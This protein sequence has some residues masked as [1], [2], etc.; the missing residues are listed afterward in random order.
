MSLDRLQASYFP[1]ETVQVTVHVESDKELKIQEGRVALICREEFQYRTTER[2]RDSQGRSSTRTVEHWMRSEQE[3]FRQVFLG[4]GSLAPMTVQTFQFA[5]SLPMNALPSL[6]GNIVKVS[7]FVKATLD[8]KMTSDINSEV[9]VNVLSAMPVETNPGSFGQSTEPG[10]VALSFELPELDY[11]P[12]QMISGSLLVAPQNKFDASE[13]RVELEQLEL[14]SHE[15][16]HRKGNKIQ[17]KLTGKTGFQPGNL[18]RI[19]FQVQ[20]PNPCLVS[21]A[22]NYWWV[23]FKLRGVL[24]RSL[25]KDTAVEVEVRIYSAR[26][27]S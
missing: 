12:G 6:V 23:G 15:Q 8:R 7:W 19:P 2:Y 3:L 24:A 18:V 9:V 5:A 20:V 14:V 10:E 11:L 25:R 17:V 26:K 22:T 1:G 27:G 4:D 13:V 16:G 21:A